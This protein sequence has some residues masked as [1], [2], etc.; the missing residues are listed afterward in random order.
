[1]NPIQ[2]RIIERVNGFTEELAPLANACR[3]YAKFCCAI[4]TDESLNIAHRPWVAPLNYLI[5]LYAPAKKSWFTK[6]KQIHDVGIPK[7]IQSVLLQSNG[8]FAFGVSFFGM[9]SAMLKEPPRLD[10]SRLNC[11]DIALANKDRGWKSEY[12]IDQLLFY[13]AYRHYTEA[14]NVGYFLDKNGDIY[15]FKKSGEQIGMWSSFSA[16][17]DSELKA[18][19]DRE[20]SGEE[21]GWLH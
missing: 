15:C 11:H 17:L 19:E 18:S 3:K 16:F 13:F 5:K 10:R 2:N 8:F 14:A 4:D 20:C 12:H 6:Y 7:P 1:M 21:L 9:S